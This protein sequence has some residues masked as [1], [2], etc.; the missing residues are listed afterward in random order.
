MNAK[1]RSIHTRKTNPPLLRDN[2]HGDLLALGKKMERW[3][4]EGT[5]EE[6]IAYLDAMPSLLKTG[7][8]KY[9]LGQLYLNLGKAEE[10]KTRLL[11]AAELS[12][13]ENDSDRGAAALCLLGQ[14]F[15]IYEDEPDSSERAQAYFA[16][17][18]ALD[19]NYIPAYYNPQCKA[20][21]NGDE[22]QFRAYFKDLEQMCRDRLD[23]PWWQIPQ[24][25]ER[26]TND[27]E[28]KKARA[29]PFWKEAIQPYLDE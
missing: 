29:F 17:A 28:L 2:L 13:K 18:R 1:F 21:R 23:T 25:L 11:E 27:P 24:L 8:G 5:E 19:P 10:A 15:A 4:N 14:L 20:A 26:F 7:L 12:K 22:A 3:I 16:E 6:G 9:C